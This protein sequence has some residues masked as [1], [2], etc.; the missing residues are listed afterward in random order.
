MAICP[1][2][3]A[4]VADTAAFC[5]QCGGALM[6]KPQDPAVVPPASE[7]SA[8]VSPVGQPTSADNSSPSYI[9]APGG[10]SVPLYAASS[11]QFARRRAVFSSDGEFVSLCAARRRAIFSPD[12]KPASLYAATLQSSSIWLWPAA[13]PWIFLSSGHLSGK[14]PHQHGHAR[15]VNIESA[16]LLHTA[17]NCW[18]CHDGESAKRDEC[19]GGREAAEYGQNFQSDWHYFGIYLSNF[20]YFHKLYYLKEMAGQVRR[21]LF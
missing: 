10:K 8:S 4:Q 15:V 21:P 7:D 5:T 2:C 20:C 1:Y 18:P 12:R 14:R 19:P 13:A 11:G 3:G 16:L 6:P 9:H 17:G